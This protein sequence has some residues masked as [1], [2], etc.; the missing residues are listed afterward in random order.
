MIEGIIAVD[1]SDPKGFSPFILKR[2]GI[3]E[4]AILLGYASGDKA[5][6]LLQAH[7]N[8]GIVIIDRLYVTESFRRFGIGGL[9]LED[10]LHRCDGAGI[11]EIQAMYSFSE[12][13]RLEAHIADCLFFRFGFD[14]VESLPCYEF[15]LGDVLESSLNPMQRRK[16]KS[17]YRANNPKIKYMRHDQR[18]LTQDGR[19]PDVSFK[20]HLDESQ[21]YA[22]D[23]VIRGCLILDSAGEGIAI[24]DFRARG[25]MMIMELFTT[26]ILD[27]LEHY[28]EDT[29]LYASP[30]DQKIK[31]LISNL[32]N[33][34]A[35]CTAVTTRYSYNYS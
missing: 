6:G 31:Q 23:N 22:S 34:K 27:G 17:C 29:T 14:K 13:D 32:S 25:A 4:N 2:K 15:K 11:K 21:F 9:L 18:S 30:V 12:N 7:V 28:P 16:S 10:L 24:S 8:A 1:P 19:W 20:G 3:E 33:K 5:V 26:A 35:V